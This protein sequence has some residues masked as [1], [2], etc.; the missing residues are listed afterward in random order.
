MVLVSI[1]TYSV[2]DAKVSKVVLF[3]VQSIIVTS[4]VT[5]FLFL[6]FLGY[7][8]IFALNYKY[9]Q[10][11]V[12]ILL[13]YLTLFAGMLID[14]AILKREPFDFTFFFMGLIMSVLAGALF[15]AVFVM[16]RFVWSVIF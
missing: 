15:P 8:Y 3:L 9:I 1:I 6:L 4:L 12:A 10:L 7:Q 5:S 2:R 16:S 13:I 14:N 11:S